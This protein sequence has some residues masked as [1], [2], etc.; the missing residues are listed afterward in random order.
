[1]WAPSLGATWEHGNGGAKGSGLCWG[2][3]GNRWGEELGLAVWG[4]PGLKV[5][6]WHGRGASS[7]QG[8]G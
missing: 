3:W 1:M 2:H 6:S 5:C 8:G 4:K 7:A